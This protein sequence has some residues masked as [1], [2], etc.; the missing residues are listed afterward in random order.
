MIQITFELDEKEIQAVFQ[1]R[2]MVYVTYHVITS[3]I[4]KQK[5]EIERQVKTYLKQN[6]L[7]FTVDQT[8]ITKIVQ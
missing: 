2:L 7:L 4:Q 8:A 3:E 6:P 1:E 5:P